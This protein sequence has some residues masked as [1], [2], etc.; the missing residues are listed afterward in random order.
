MRMILFWT[1]FDASTSTTRMR[2]SE[3][4]RNSMC[5]KRLS[6]TGGETTMPTFS[7]SSERTCETFSISLEGCAKASDAS[8]SPRSMAEMSARDRRASPM[9]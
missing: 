2:P 3:S 8:P 1:T 9:K 4:G 7:E 6:A 5:S